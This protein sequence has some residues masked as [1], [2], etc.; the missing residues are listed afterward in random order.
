M[1]ADKKFNENYNN[2]KYQRSNDRN[3]WKK[4]FDPDKHVQSYSVE[5]TPNNWKNEWKKRF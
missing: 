3:T 4:E 5:P 1:K 2:D